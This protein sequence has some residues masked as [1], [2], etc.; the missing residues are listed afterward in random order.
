MK[1]KIKDI[2]VEVTGVPWV[3]LKSRRR[4]GLIVFARTL[5]VYLSTTDYNTPEY[6]S[7]ADDVGI[8]RSSVYH[9]RKRIKE[10][11][12]TK[13][14]TYYPYIQE[15]TKRIALF[16]ESSAFVSKL[17]LL[18]PTLPLTQISEN[19]YM[20]SVKRYSFVGLVVDVGREGDIE[21]DYIPFFD[22]LLAGGFK[23]WFAKTYS[24]ALQIINKYMVF[25]Y[26]T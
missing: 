18:Y 22:S 21:G 14:K 17:K 20:I 3:T 15:A 23:I 9:C 8:N 6:Y 19:C 7:V 16:S 25:D 4:D 26:E 1:Q 13:D 2:V 24:E 5:Y 10:L 12:E 11:I